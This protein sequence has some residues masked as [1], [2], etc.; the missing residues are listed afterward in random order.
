M[1]Y[2]LLSFHE[3]TPSIEGVLKLTELPSI[4]GL[5]IIANYYASFVNEV[6]S[7]SPILR[8]KPLSCRPQESIQISLRLLHSHHQQLAH[9]QVSGPTHSPSK[10][11]WLFN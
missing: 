11:Y 2:T 6:Y 1:I 10:V 8:A 9:K 5:V 4:I 7:P 3:K